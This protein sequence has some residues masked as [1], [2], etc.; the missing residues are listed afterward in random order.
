MRR[1]NLRA[2]TSSTK[3]QKKP[4]S[5]KKVE[6]KKKIVAKKISTSKNLSEEDQ[7]VEIHRAL[8]AFKRGDFSVR[9]QSSG[10]KIIGEISE[11]INDIIELNEDT[12][13]EL[14]RMATQVGREGRMGERAFIGYNKGAW[15]ANIQSINS[16]IFPL[17]ILKRLLIRL[18]WLSNNLLKD[19]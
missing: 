16:L 10:G 9:I 19:K 15:A 12:S 2:Q 17:L 5:K 6:T 8:K 14:T 7:L 18:R 1:K 11:L 13:K 3:D 4:I